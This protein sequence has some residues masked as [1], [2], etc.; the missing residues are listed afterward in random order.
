MS[1]RVRAVCVAGVLAFLL[2]LGLPASA[3]AQWGKL[4]KL[5]GPGPF[6]GEIYE[7]RVVCFGDL[8]RAAVLTA[9]AE[10]LSTR[11]RALERMGHAQ[12]QDAATDAAAKWAEAADAWARELGE[13]APTSVQEDEVRRMANR[14]RAMLT[15]TSSA[16]VLWSL[17]NPNRQRRLA[18]D[19]GWSTLDADGS[20]S[21]AQG[22]PINLDMLMGSVSWRVVANPNWDVVEV[23]AGA[24]TY[25]FTSA[26]FPSLKGVVLQPARLTFRAPSLWSSLRVREEGKRWWTAFSRP[27]LWGRIAAI[28]TYSVGV[29][30]F[31]NGFEPDDFAGRGSTAVRIPSELLTTKYFFVNVEPI[32]RVFGK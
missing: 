15:A 6:S 5:S 20:D 18:I 19:V 8:S 10:A 23:S 4:E 30:I 17:C 29:T 9:E 24:G 14:G 3:D 25:W 1:L 27:A 12:R 11:A 26:G 13:D 21:Y 22:N 32:L 31:P 28:P 16:G 7:F 2:Q